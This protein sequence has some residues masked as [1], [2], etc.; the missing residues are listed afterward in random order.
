[1]VWAGLWPTTG[2][3][4]TGFAE[5]TAGFGRAFGGRGRATGPVG[6]HRSGFEG[7]TTDGLICVRT[8]GTGCGGTFVGPEGWFWLDSV[9]ITISSGL[10]VSATPKSASSKRSPVCD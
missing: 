2:R 5:T 4:S 8:G 3:P 10:P 7:V 6:F 1:M 9:S